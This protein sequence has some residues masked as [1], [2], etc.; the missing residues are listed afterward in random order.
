MQVASFAAI[1]NSP[2]GE[3]SSSLS[4]FCA[5]RRKIE[6]ALGILGENFAGGGQGNAAAKALKKLGF[7][8]VFQ[9]ADLGADGGLRAVTRLRSLGETL[10]ADDFEERVQ[11]IKIH[12]LPQAA[13]RGTAFEGTRLLIDYPLI[14]SERGT[15][16]RENATLKSRVPG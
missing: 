6:H 14:L 8:L 5:W 9:L 7:Q 16:P 13:K 12:T 4:E 10:Q 2:R 1:T 11:L 3:V 15:A